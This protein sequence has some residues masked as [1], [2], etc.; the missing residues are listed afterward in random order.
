VIKLLNIADLH[1]H[2]TASDGAY[3]LAE[4]AQKARGEDIEIIAITDHDS[5]S[6]FDDVPAGLSIEVVPGVELSAELGEREVH[7]LGYFLDVKNAALVAT[8]T[9]LREKR[10]RRIESIADRLAELNVNIDTGG[11]LAVGEGSSVGRLHV[12]EL[13]INHGY[14]TNVYQAF[15]DYLGPYGKAFVPKA[16][17][18]T[19]EAIGLIHSSGGA[20]ILAHPGSFFTVDEVRIFVNEGLDGIEAVYPAHSPADT[21]MWM[22]FARDNGLLTTAGS[23]FHG[24]GIENKLGLV[25]TTRENVQVLQAR[26]QKYG[27]RRVS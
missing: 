14:S 11:I 25:K 26:S 10:R 7:V 18:K 1:V 4:V 3:S 16:R 21:E 23:D 19:A 13:L 5:V 2:T 6:A 17:L 9:G 12:A 27:V 8:L 20:A 15:R 22:G 24:R